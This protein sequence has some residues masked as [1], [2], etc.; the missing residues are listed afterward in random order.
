MH[1]C[2]SPTR[3]KAKSGQNTSQWTIGLMWTKTSRSHTTGSDLLK[4]SKHTERGQRGERRLRALA[5]C[6]WQTSVKYCLCLVLAA[7]RIDEA[8]WNSVIVG[9]AENQSMANA[10]FLPP[11]CKAPRHLWK[12]SII[13]SH[14]ARGPHGPECVCVCVDT[15]SKMPKVKKNSVF[16][17]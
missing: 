15:E 16:Y 9:A 11:P 17:L 4:L 6:L 2:V 14:K 5:A 3:I 13:C 12:P 10:A 7:W 1:N 8:E